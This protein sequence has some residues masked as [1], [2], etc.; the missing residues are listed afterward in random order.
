MEMARERFRISALAESKR[1]E[2]MLCD[3]RFRCGIQWDEWVALKRRQQGR[4][5]LTINRIPEFVKH[6]ANNMRQARPGIKIDPTGDGADEE[7]AEIRQGLIRYIEMNSRA[8]IAYDTAFE[9]LCT[10]GLGYARIVDGWSDPKSMDKDLFVQW[11]PNT[12]AVYEDPSA[13]K[14]DWSDGKYK[15]IVEDLSLPEFRA[16]FG[17][18]KQAASAENFQSI[19]DHAPLWLTDGKIRVAEYWHIEEESTVVCELDDGTTAYIDELQPEDADRIVATRPGKVPRV[20]QDFISGLERLKPTRDWQ[21]RYIPIIPFIGNQIELDG[22]RILVGMVRYARE[23]QRMYNYMYTSFVEAI[24]LAPKA[25]FIA[26]FDQ[27]QEF[28]AIWER[29]NTDPMAVLPYRNVSA[30]NGAPLPPPQRQQAEPP[31]GAFVQGLQLADQNLKATF[32]IYDASLGQRGP[33]ESGIAIN[34]RKIESDVANYDWI[35]NFS[36]G[37]TFLGIVLDDLLQYYYNKPGRVVQ[38]LREDQ[39]TRPVTLN[40]PYTDPRTGKTK[41]YDLSKG[42]FSHTVSS[43]PSFLTRRQEAA[44][45]MME[46]VKVYPPLMQIAGPMIIKEQDWPGKDAIAAQMEKA[47]PPELRPQDPDAP[48][49]S[50]ADQQKMQQQQQMIQQ[51][52]QALT[53]ATDKKELE[54]MKQDYETFRAQMTQETQLAMAQLKTGSAEAKFMNDKIFEELERIHSVL[55]V[56]IEQQSAPPTPGT[57]APP[58]GQPAIAPQQQAAP[59]AGPPQSPQPAAPAGVP[60][61]G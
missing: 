40:K 2:E 54:K 8:N 33:Q 56:T 6:A 34:S 49:T 50:Q 12:F 5:C 22:E 30:E 10:I 32:S 38:I 47:M 28:R 17:R 45:A 41:V 24:A 48:V 27:I 61:A 39:S 21:G 1:R 43:G 18:K 14:P 26:E 19:G 7:I 4:P 51:L 13:A 16:R 23:S 46:T 29:A 53:L 11:V 35:D 42:K 55:G 36:R 25:P 37:V 20:K 57:P 58:S 44:K 60:P 31:I 3:L 15:F 9:N 52:T 59:P